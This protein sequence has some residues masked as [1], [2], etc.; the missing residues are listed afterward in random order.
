MLIFQLLNDPGL[1]H[2]NR[3][4]NLVKKHFY[5]ENSIILIPNS[6]NLTLYLENQNICNVLKYD[7]NKT[8]KQIIDLVDKKVGLWRIREW[9]IDTKFNCTKLLVALKKSKVFSV[10][11][12][13]QT[14]SR[15]LA[16]KIY[17][18]LYYLIKMI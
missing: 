14:N 2:C 7:T 15:L 13:N 4:I 6:S 8:S 3:V 11:I 18:Q 1:G 12:D 16:D 9:L 17:I 5:S 10:L